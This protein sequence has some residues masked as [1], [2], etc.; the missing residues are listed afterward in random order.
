M[1]CDAQAISYERMIRYIALRGAD[2]SCTE[3]RLDCS[4]D[5][6][7]LILLMGIYPLCTLLQPRRPD[8]F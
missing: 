5:N 3:D 1:D 2:W 4:T 7:A 8:N 6:T